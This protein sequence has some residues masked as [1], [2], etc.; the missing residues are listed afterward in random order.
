MSQGGHCSQKMSLSPLQ[1]HFVAHKLRTV[2]ESPAGR[3]KLRLPQASKKVWWGKDASKFDSSCPFSPTPASSDE[4]EM[5]EIVRRAVHWILGPRVAPTR[6]VIPVSLPAA[7]G[8]RGMDKEARWRHGVP[9]NCG[10][11][12]QQNKRPVTPHHVP[13]RTGASRAQA[14]T[15]ICSTKC[16]SPAGSITRNKAGGGFASDFAL[17]VQGRSYPR[18]PLAIPDAFDGS[19]KCKNRCRLQSFPPPKS[20]GTRAS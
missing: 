12:A 19:V 10:L 1:S 6:P 9:V 20:S 16:K 11:E 4:G 17:P 3:T 18:S 14:A 8:S 2:R 15:G 13:R 7:G 5:H